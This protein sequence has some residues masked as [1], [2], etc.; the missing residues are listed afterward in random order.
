MTVFGS[1]IT[2]MV[3]PFKKDLSVDYDRAAELA[4]R[5]VE[6]GSEGI[7]VAGTTG[8]SPTLSSNEKVRLFET[9][10]EAVGT[11][12]AVLAGTGSNST[13]D[14]IALTKKAEITEV[15]GIMLV[16]P[17]YNKPPQEGLYRHFKAVAESTRLP[18]MLY[19]VPGRTG[20]NLLP[21]TV[22]RLAQISNIVAVK[23]ASGNLEQASEI[24]R[25][26]PRGFAVYSGDDSLT[27]PIMSV[28]GCGIVSVASHIVGEAMSG[29]IKSFVSGDVATAAKIHGQLMPLFKGLFFTTSP[30]PVKAALRLTGFDVGTPRLPLVDL[31]ERETEYL[32]G[33]LKE[34]GF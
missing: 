10:V 6:T 34:T 14:S 24:C 4:V 12:A 11:R 7:V 20:V 26:A 3:T 29:M 15:K 33:I 31:D 27:L 25:K 19:N 13:A 2:A 1:L 30:A 5:L 23:E 28:G 16:T 17:Y 18:V 21:A 22:L 9:V 32:R 8:E